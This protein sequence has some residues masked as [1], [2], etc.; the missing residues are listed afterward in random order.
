MLTRL[1]STLL[2]G[3]LAGALGAL[4]AAA[5]DSPEADLTLAEAATIALERHPALRAAEQAAAATAAG[6]EQA[7]AGFLP[8]LDFSETLTRGNNP[9]YAF[10]SLLNQGRFTAADFALDRLNHPQAIT[11]WRMNL[12]GSLPLFMGGRTRLG[13]EQARL[14]HQ[15]VR[16]D[17]ARIQQEVLFGVVR[18]YHGILLAEEARATVET[19]VRTA[20]ANLAAAAARHEAGVVV[21][22]DVL[23]ARV[24]LARLQ[25]EQIAATHQVELSRAVLSESMGVAP[26][27]VFRPVGPLPLPPAG[28][29]RPE[30]LERLATQHRAD[31]KRLELEERRLAL[32]IQRTKGLFLPTLHLLGNYEINSHGLAADGQD[33]WS[34][35][36]ALNWNLFS[37]GGDRARVAEAQAHYYR[38]GALKQRLANAIALE[39]RQAHLALLTAR[40]RVAVARQAVGQAEEALRIVRERYQAGL[41]TIVELLDSETALTAARTGLTRTLYDA[42]VGQAQLDLSLGRLDRTRM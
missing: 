15:A 2:S 19:A 25:E 34:V 26:G 14:G 10:G 17:Q 3:L 35:G 31:L 9:V 22:S 12:G 4:P 40:A 28:A 39:V 5:Q 33:S 30:E 37:G 20:E 21:A 13:Y 11:N 23:A 7:R 8:R 29:E 41:T 16:H 18:A 36:L 6:I 1:T 38:L 32:E 24:R 42:A 27:R